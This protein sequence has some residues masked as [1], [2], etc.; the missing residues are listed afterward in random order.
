MRGGVVSQGLQCRV[1]KPEF[2]YR[3]H[4]SP[5]VDPIVSHIYIYVYKRTN[6]A[7]HIYIYAYMAIRIYIYIYIY[8]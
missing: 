5:S 7:T 4:K 1:S 3:V 8:I 6:L 2:H